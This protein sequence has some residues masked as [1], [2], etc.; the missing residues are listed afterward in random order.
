MNS[1]R[2]TNGANGALI[3]QQTFTRDAVGNITQSID[4]DG[5]HAYT[6]DAERRLLTA[7]HGSAAFL[8]AESY[9]YD[10]AGNR[11]TSHASSNHVYSRN[12]LLQ[13]DQFD[14]A[15]DDEGNLLRKV[16]RQDSTSTH[17]TYDPKNRLIQIQA[18]NASGVT[19]STTSYT[20]DTQGR[21]LTQTSG[22]TTTRFV[23]DGLNPIL[24]LSDTGAVLNRRLYGRVVDSVYADESSGATRWF[25]T[26]TAGHV[27]ELVG[28]GGESISRLSYDA[29]GNIKRATGGLASNDLVFGAREASD[30]GLI[31]FRARS[32]DPPTGRFT[33]EDPE[34]DFDYVY[35]RNNPLVFGD[36]TGETTIIE[37]S[38]TIRGRLFNVALHG[39][40]HSWRILGRQLFCIHIQLLTAL[41]RAAGGAPGNGTRIQI[42]LP[43][44]RGT[45]FPRF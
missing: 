36:P 25:L 23:Y 1:V 40:H 37:Y 12:R 32:F 34:L 16:S 18:R 10:A 45:R 4:F 22:G 20:Y 43:W 41:T 19:T 21:R 13:N 31:Y 30:A 42:P 38:I 29:F 33:Q 44:C 5:V 26:E 35:A 7:S 6:Y 39:G 17:F 8:P 28:N 11:T 24:K 15:Y 14:Y 9:Q 27:R 3:Q 2:H